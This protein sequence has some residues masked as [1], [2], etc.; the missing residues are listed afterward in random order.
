MSALIR[1]ALAAASVVALA[2]GLMVMAAG[3][4]HAAGETEVSLDG[5]NFSAGITA[6]LYNDIARMIPGDAQHRTVYVRNSGA[7]AGYL[8]VVLA[9]VAYTDLDFANALTLQTVIAGATTPPKVPLSLAD[10]CWVL[11][12]G[13]LVGPGETVTIDTSAD[14]GML[15]GVRG[16]GASATATLTATLSDATPGSISPSACGRPDVSVPITPGS[17]V[18]AGTPGAI[19]DPAA[20]TPGE[21]V[22]GTTGGDLPV[23]SLPGGITIDPNTWHLLEEWLVLI[24]FA[25]LLLGAGWFALIKRRRRG[26]TSEASEPLETMP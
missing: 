9:D 24:L 21:L 10:P 26:D 17:P 6:P 7:D 20:G 12:E 19:I 22:P 1:A 15:D 8:R 13:V 5:T 4:A 25:S 3:P 18:R 16:Q 11:I 14:L 23:L 2:L